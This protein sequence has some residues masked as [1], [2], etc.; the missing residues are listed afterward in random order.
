MAKNKKS[1]VNSNHPNT[2][3]CGMIFGLKTDDTRDSRL[4]LA[5]K[6]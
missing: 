1:A 4:V 6:V 2:E 5:C 3:P